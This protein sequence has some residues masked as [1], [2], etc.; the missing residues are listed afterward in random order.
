MDD[1]QI[2]GWY[3]R[4]P[5]GGVSPQ[6]WRIS[7]GAASC[8]NVMDPELGIG[9]YFRASVGETIWE[10]IRRETPWMDDLDDPGP[11]IRMPRAPGVYHRRIARPV[12]GNGYSGMELPDRE[13][14]TRFLVGAQAQLQTLVSELEGICRIVEPTRET[15]PV[16][17]HAIR[18]LIMLAATEA[19]MH[20]RGVL[21]ANGRNADEATTRH[22]AMLIEPL[23]LKGYSVLFPGYP[24][25]DAFRP[26]ETWDA[27]KATRTLDW[28]SAYNAVKHDREHKFSEARLEHAFASIA[29]CAILLVAQF[30]ELALPHEVRRLVHI[31]MP[32]RSIQ[33]YYLP[34]IDEDGWFAA[35]YPFAS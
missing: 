10:A 33:D 2:E 7:A 35:P 18:N 26:F 16:H 1:E 20:W 31:Q 3:V 21:T 6:L 23:G 34:P 29:A 30:G 19:E 15:L 17:G 27:A 5:D 22:Y 28:Y 8:M 13:A 25:L 9:T 14:E 11:F 12:F 4:Y 32:D 24:D